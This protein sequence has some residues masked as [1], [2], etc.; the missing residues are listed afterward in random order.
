MPASPPITPC[1]TLNQRQVLFPTLETPS[2]SS[3]PLAFGPFALSLCINQGFWKKFRE[4][5]YGIL[6]LLTWKVELKRTRHAQVMPLLVSL[7]HRHS[8]SGCQLIG[9]F[10]VE[11]VNPEISSGLPIPEMNRNPAPA[12]RPELYATPA[13]EASDIAFNPVSGPEKPNFTLDTESSVY[14]ST[15]L[16]A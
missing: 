8:P 5:I 13:T 9:D 12:S 4:P 2:Q 6:L 1:T 14:V 16:Q 15:V 10:D 7:L 3:Y 11:T